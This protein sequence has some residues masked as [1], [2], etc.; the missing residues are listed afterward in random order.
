V[1]ECELKAYQRYDTVEASSEVPDGLVGPAAWTNEVLQAWLLEHAR[2]I[3]PND[4]VDPHA[5]LFAQGFDRCAVS[6]NDE[7]EDITHIVLFFTV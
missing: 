7:V 6:Q 1:R 5:D 4:S 3:S 2:T